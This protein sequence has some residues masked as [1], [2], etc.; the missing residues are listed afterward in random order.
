[1]STAELYDVIDGACFSVLPV[2]IIAGGNSA[3]RLVEQRLLAPRPYSPPMRRIFVLN[4]IELMVVLG[5]RRTNS[6]S[7]N[8]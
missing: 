8:T 1:M 2:T 7:M 6:E 3:E 5:D 4:E